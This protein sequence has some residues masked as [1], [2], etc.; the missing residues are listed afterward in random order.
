MS[1]SP[2]SWRQDISHRRAVRSGAN[3][4]TEMSHL[5]CHHCRVR[6]TAEAATYLLACPDCARPTALVDDSGRL[7]GYRLFDPLDLTDMVT[8]GREVSPARRR[9]GGRRP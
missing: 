6:F 3:R 4:P 5:C 7:M 9:P 8:G 1:R 2:G